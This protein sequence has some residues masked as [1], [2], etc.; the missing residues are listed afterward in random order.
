LDMPL[1][2]KLC[3]ISIQLSYLHCKCSHLLDQMKV[4]S[5][6]DVCLQRIRKPMNRFLGTEPFLRTP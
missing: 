6:A 4:G 1:L 5:Y 2:S 3:V